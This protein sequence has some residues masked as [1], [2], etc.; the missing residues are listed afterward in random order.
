MHSFSF[1]VGNAR[2]AVEFGYGVIEG[3]EYIV[4]S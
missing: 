3:I 4:S 1:A 2:N